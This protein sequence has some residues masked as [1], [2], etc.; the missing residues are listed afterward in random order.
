M[1]NLNNMNDIDIV[2]NNLNI[3]VFVAINMIQD[4]VPIIEGIFKSYEEAE[5]K[6]K[7]K[8]AFIHGPFT[9]NIKENKIPMMGKNGIITNYKTEL[10]L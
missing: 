4:C 7:E 10:S 9:L 6:T 1:Y 2:R 8:N 3:E 5:K